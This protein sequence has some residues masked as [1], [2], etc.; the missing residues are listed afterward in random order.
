MSSECP[1]DTSIIRTNKLQNDRVSIQPCPVG[2]QHHNVLPV[3]I[4]RLTCLLSSSCLN[5][6][7]PLPNDLG[8]LLIL[9]LQQSKRIRHII[10]LPLRLDSR[11]SRSELGS[12]LLGMLVL[13]YSLAQTLDKTKNISKHTFSINPDRNL[14]IL[15]NWSSSNSSLLDSKLNMSTK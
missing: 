5:N 10:P 12:Q 9:V 8:N 13:S 4:T 1:V 6:F 15:L 7:I 11:Q 14:M 2:L 3:P